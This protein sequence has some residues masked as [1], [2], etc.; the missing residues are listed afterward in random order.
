MVLTSSVTTIDEVIVGWC[1]EDLLNRFPQVVLQ[2][3]LVSGALSN[4]AKFSAKIAHVVCC[5][6]GPQMTPV[7]QVTD[8]DVAFVLKGFMRRS[9]DNLVRQMKD[10]A[11]AAGAHVS[12]RCDA[13]EIMTIC[14]ESHRDFAKT[15]QDTKLALRA[16]RRNGQFAWRPD[17]LRGKLVKVDEQPWA[18]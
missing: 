12:F 3:D 18:K 6:I 8:T 1:M 10:R 2:R 5:W 11:S 7:V 17:I 13:F 9:K 16:L 15:D 14:S 4:T